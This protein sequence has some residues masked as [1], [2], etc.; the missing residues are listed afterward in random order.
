MSKEGGRVPQ[1]SYGGRYLYYVKVDRRGLWRVD[2]TAS[3]RSETCVIADIEPVDW[4]NWHVLIV[5]SRSG[6]RAPEGAARD[7]RRRR[8]PPSDWRIAIS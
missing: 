2:L 8:P 7:G 4:N 6:K 1:L 5:Q 3:Q